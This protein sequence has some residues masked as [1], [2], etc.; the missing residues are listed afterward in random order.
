MKPTVHMIFAKQDDVKAISEF[1]R[2]IPEG[3]Q[4]RFELTLGQ[5]YQNEGYAR[6]SLIGYYLHADGQMAQCLIVT[7]IFAYQHRMIA[8]YHNAHDRSM[9]Q[10]K[11]DVERLL[12][13][14]LGLDP[15]RIAQTV[16]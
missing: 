5:A 15:S 12:G 2:Q 11:E 3:E 9:Q 13:L 7:N 8:D 1:L 16:Y 10:L 14:E 4:F 6:A